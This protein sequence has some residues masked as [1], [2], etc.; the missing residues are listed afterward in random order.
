[1]PTF[2]TYCP[3]LLDLELINKSRLQL[4]DQQKRILGERLFLELLREILG[5]DDGYEVEDQIFTSPALVIR[6]RGEE[7]RVEPQD[8]DEN[9]LL[10]LL[11]L[12][13]DVGKEGWI[14]HW[15]WLFH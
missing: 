11:E 14:S 2:K 5:R 6:S 9:Y 1:M 10:L 3:Y 4:M 13:L 8:S 12:C 7:I 15:V